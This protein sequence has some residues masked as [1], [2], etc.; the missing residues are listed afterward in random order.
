MNFEQWCK[1]KPRGTLVEIWRT[2]GVSYSTLQRASH[3]KRIRWWSK[4]VAISEA[5]G[6]EVS[7][8]ELCEQQPGKE[9]DN[10][11]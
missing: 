1:G 11:R 10:V 8:K 2:S 4:A 5:T 9:K 7:P 6:G 3:G